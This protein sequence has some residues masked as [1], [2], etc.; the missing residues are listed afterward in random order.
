MRYGRRSQ[1]PLADSIGSL[2]KLPKS[3]EA[4]EFIKNHLN[5]NSDKKS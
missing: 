1:E 2:Y 3:K 5:P 4:E